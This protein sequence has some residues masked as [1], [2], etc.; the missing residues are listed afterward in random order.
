MVRLG[1]Q[2]PSSASRRHP[3]RGTP[4]LC[5]PAI[6]SAASAAYQFRFPGSHS[7]A[8]FTASTAWRTRSASSLLIRSAT[9]RAT[10][11]AAPTQTRD[12]R[13]AGTR[14]AARVGRHAARHLGVAGRGE[15]EHRVRARSRRSAESRRSSR[16][17]TAPCDRL[18]AA[19]VARVGLAGR[20]RGSASTS[21][22][23]APDSSSRA[24]RSMPSSV[25]GN[26]VENSGSTNAAADGSIAQRGP[27]A[28]ARAVAEARHPVEPARRRTRPRTARA[29]DGNR[30]SSRC[31]A[32]SPSARRS[33]VGQRIRHRHAGAGHA[34]AEAQHP[35]PPAVEHVVQ[36]GVVHRIRRRVAARGR[37]PR[38]SRAS[39]RTAP[40]R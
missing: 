38:D 17:R 6:A 35:H 24:R 18:R 36:R 15:V 22:K 31:H 37:A 23:N 20:S 29:T 7:P 4:S 26:P 1:S 9:R 12:R 40:R 3:S 34:V 33:S 2:T 25:S 5:A 14:L 10:A 30:S 11:R 8:M 19:C 27:A 28:D 16:P 13:R 39:R 21:P 32:G